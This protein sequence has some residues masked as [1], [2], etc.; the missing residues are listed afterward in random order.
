MS[1]YDVASPDDHGEPLPAATLNTTTRTNHLDRFAP[2][3]QRELITTAIILV[4]NEFAEDIAGIVAGHK[5]FDDTR[6]DALAPAGT[7]IARHIIGFVNH[8]IR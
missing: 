2:E 3:R 7:I 4:L 5:L 1:A 6:S 8:C